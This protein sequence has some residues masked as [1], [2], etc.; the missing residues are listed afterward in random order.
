MSSRF[1]RYVV[2]HGHFSQPPRENPWTEAIEKQESAFPFHD[3][4]QRIARECY[5]PNG[6]ARVVDS[7]RKIIDLVNNYSYMSFNFGPTL[8]SWY[9]IH[10][11]R[12]YERILKA[13]E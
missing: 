3:W 7:Q 5:S 2:I 6:M 12:E 8:L 4:N 9:E 11:P 13:D 10:H 1:P